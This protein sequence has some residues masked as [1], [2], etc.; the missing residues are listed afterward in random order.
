MELYRFGIAELT[1]MLENR[2]LSARDIHDSVYRRIDAVEGKIR[3]Y[4]TITKEKA[5]AMAE[6]ADKERQCEDVSP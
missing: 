6:Q 4:V 1:G 2:E 5:L 3:A